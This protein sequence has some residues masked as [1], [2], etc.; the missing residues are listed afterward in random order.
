V[1]DN[2]GKK[3]VLMDARDWKRGRAGIQN[4]VLWRSVTDESS[5]KKNPLGGK[6]ILKGNGKNP[7]TYEKRIRT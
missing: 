6:G 3:I 2:K 7:D 4:G 1:G 5:K